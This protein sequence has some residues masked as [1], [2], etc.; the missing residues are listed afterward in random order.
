MPANGS[1]PLT[2]DLMGIIVVIF[3]VIFY[4]RLQDNHLRCKNDLKYVTVT[5]RIIGPNYLEISIRQLIAH[6]QRYL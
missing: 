3:V 4:H 1:S 6:A 5:S 2:S